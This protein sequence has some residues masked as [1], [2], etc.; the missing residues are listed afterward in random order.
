MKSREYYALQALAHVLLMFLALCAILPFVLLFVSSFT[1]QKTIL[2]KGYSFIPQDFSLEAYEYLWKQKNQ[3]FR[4]Y[5]VT[6]FITAV[7]TFCNILITTLFAYPLSRRDLPGRN[8]FSFLVFFTMLFNG[9][10]VPTY[11]VYTGYFHMKNNI[12]SLMIPSLLMSPWYVFLMRTYL[13]ENIPAAVIESARI[14]GA[15]ELVV[16]FKIIFPMGKPM[17]A[18]VGLFAGI[19]YWNDWYNGMIYLTKP[20]LFSIQNLLNR[21]LAD[22]QF[23]SNNANM[24][25]TMVA[26]T[27]IPGTTVRMAIAAIGVLP[28][29]VIYPF[30]QN[31]FVKGIAVGAV[32]G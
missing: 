1:A 16:F 8:K 17:I 19:A 4:A 22:I 28:I 14:D 3:I 25:S 11:L 23:L 10:L 13:A 18:T 24:A 21:I 26:S 9:G 6:I 30:V 31:N 32:K 29:I 2:L 15:N 7:G 20:N 27:T 5:G 12:L